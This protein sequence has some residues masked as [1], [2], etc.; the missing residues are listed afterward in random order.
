VQAVQTALVSYLNAL[1]IG[2]V[3]SIAALY[4]ELM[5]I[6]ATLTAPNFGV[7]SMTIGVATATTTASFSNAST[8]MTVASATGIV[9]GQLVV[10]A[11]VASGTTVIGVS[12][13]TI[14]LSHATVAAGSSTSTVF[15]TLSSS[16]ITMPNF[17]Y[18]AFGDAANVSVVA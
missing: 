5:A 14:T 12:G 9:N 3:V 8:S 10:G 16:D 11:G 15:S 1:A 17:Y 7:Q 18:A 13:T 4:Y 6:N 2:E